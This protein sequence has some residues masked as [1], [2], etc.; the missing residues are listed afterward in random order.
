MKA[1]TLC[2]FMK[3][4]FLG[5]CVADFEIAMKN[6][7]FSPRFVLFIGYTVR[8]NQICTKCKGESMGM[9]WNACKIKTLRQKPLQN[10]H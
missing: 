9:Q 3:Y 1:P 6:N 10:H 2:L 8:S 5:L 7:C 4:A